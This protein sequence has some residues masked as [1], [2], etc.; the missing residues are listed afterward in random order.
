MGEI[1]TNANCVELYMQINDQV[2]DLLVKPKHNTIKGQVKDLLVKPKHEML[3]YYQ[4]PTNTVQ[5]NKIQ[6]EDLLV[7]PKNEMLT[8]EGSMVEN[9]LIPKDKFQ[10]ALLYPL[11]NS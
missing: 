9:H 10:E 2:K 8:V 7:M 5:I 3:T 1:N 6:V 4:I 11:F